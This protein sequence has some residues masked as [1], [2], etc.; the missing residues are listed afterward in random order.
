MPNTSV[1]LTSLA[2]I[3]F[4]NS[5]VNCFLLHASVRNFVQSS[6]MKAKQ[7]MKVP[8]ISAVHRG[9]PLELGLLGGLV[10][11]GLDKGREGLRPSVASV[12]VR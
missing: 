5:A 10:E 7:R 9:L 3:P 4:L 11:V 6:I 8:A 2:G 1:E 12:R